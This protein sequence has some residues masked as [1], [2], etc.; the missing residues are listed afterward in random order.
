MSTTTQPQPA[1]TPAD[2][3]IA[4]ANTTATAVESLRTTAPDAYALLLGSAGT[5]TKSG[6]APVIGMIVGAVVAHFGLACPT[7]GTATATCLTH[8]TITLATTLITV[9]FGAGAALINHWISKAPGRALATPAA[10][11]DVIVPKPP[12][13]PTTTAS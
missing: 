3:A 1:R 13:A 5:Y 8:D 9:A 12:T 2:N 7:T 10:A 4:M 11:P 6:L